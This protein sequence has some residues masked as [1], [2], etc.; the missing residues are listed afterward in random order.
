MCLPFSIRVLG[1]QVRSRE[2]W[3]GLAHECG[4][5]TRKP[6]RLPYGKDW[7]VFLLTQSTILI[8]K[9]PKESPPLDQDHQTG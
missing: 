3:E 6:E 9:N 7:V 1:P 4:D 2:K 5:H 8:F